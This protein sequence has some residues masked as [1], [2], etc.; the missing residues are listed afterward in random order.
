MIT[1]ILFIAIA[2]ATDTILCMEQGIKNVNECQNILITSSKIEN[3][4]DKSDCIEYIK[5]R[6]L[7]IYIKEGGD[8]KL[9]HLKYYK[10][11]K[12]NLEE[13][14]NNEEV[15]PIDKFI[16]SKTNTIHNYGNI[17]KDENQISI[18]K[19]YST[20]TSRMYN[21]FNVHLKGEGKATQDTG[22]STQ[23][24]G[25]STQ[26]TGKSTQDTGKS[27]QDTGKTTQDTGKTTQDTG[28]ST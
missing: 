13:K 6:S 5:G 7:K 19:L 10:D 2:T 3:S 22:K 25:K 23:D 21:I 9:Y 15:I 16:I 14:N 17:Y 11:T 20:V 24:T 12:C 28:K 4:L 26:D 8:K 1:V 18:N 27:T